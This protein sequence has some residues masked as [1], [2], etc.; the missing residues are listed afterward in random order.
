MSLM[1]SCLASLDF[2]LSSV[3]LLLWFGCLDCVPFWL[4]FRCLFLFVFHLGACALLALNVCFVVVLLFLL[5]VLGC[6]Q[7]FQAVSDVMQAP[8]AFAVGCSVH[9]LCCLQL[10][11]L[12]RCSTAL[13]QRLPYLLSVLR[14]LFVSAGRFWAVVKCLSALCQHLSRS[15]LLFCDTPVLGAQVLAMVRCLSAFCQHLSHGLR[16]FAGTH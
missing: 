8:V 14:H 11:A 3:A 7:I 2:P 6:Q 16:R 12:A 4:V 5:F 9:L 1:T 15:Q 13:G 10:C